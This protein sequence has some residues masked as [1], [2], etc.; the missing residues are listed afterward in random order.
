MSAPEFIDVHVHVCRSVEQEKVVFPRPGYPDEWFWGN[1]ERISAHMDRENIS[2]IFAVNYMDTNRMTRARLARMDPA[3]AGDEDVLQE[4][5]TGMVARV[6]EFNAWVFE[7]AAKEPRIVP[8]VCVDIGLFHEQAAMMEAAERGIK[9]GAGGF[10]IHPGFS[11]FLPGDPRMFPLYERLQSADI[12]VLSH[13]G[14][15][16]NVPGSIAYGEPLNFIPVF[17]NFPRLRLIMAHAGGAFWDEREFI[18]DAF[19]QVYF[20]T[21]GGFQSSSLN[22][23]DRHRACPVEDAP[24]FIRKLGVHRVLFG[25]DGPAL[26]QRSQLHQIMALPLT[27]D[28]KRAVLS[29]NARQLMGLER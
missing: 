21:A 10:K 27:D 8:F 29:D 19:P 23:R 24:R 20:D 28:E 2:H 14:T 16:D 7:L 1:P 15:N 6:N 17:E 18:A 12:P 11:E 13:S 3:E 22:A 4:L 5:R 25:S 26:D 9:A